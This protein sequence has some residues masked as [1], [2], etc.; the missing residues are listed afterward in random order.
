MFVV[1]LR[2]GTERY[3]HVSNQMGHMSDMSDVGYVANLPLWW[4]GH[5]LDLETGLLLH[6]DL[7]EWGLVSLDPHCIAANVCLRMC[8]VRYRTINCDNPQMSPSGVW[9]RKQSL[10]L[11]LFSAWLA[12]LC[13]ICAV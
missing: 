2:V 9:G 3:A 10:A 11:A 5:Y 4:R 13:V 8:G 1:D 7:A 6:L 12:I